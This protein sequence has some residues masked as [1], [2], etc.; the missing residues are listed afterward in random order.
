[1]CENGV[2]VDQLVFAGNER[3]GGGEVVIIFAI[4]DRIGAGLAELGFL[5]GA[6]VRGVG[7]IGDR[8]GEARGDLVAVESVC[9]PA[10]AGDHGGV[11]D[12]DA[13]ADPGDLIKACERE[14][15]RSPY[16]KDGGRP[17][18]TAPGRRSEEFDFLGDD[19][20]VVVSASV[21]LVAAV[22]A[23]DDAPP[24]FALLLLVEVG[25]VSGRERGWSY[26]YNMVVA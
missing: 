23:P 26:V 4:D 2:G 18:A 11:G 8:I 15:G 14:H 19:V 9:D 17:H 24:P 6:G 22:A 10:D 1:M 5:E 7:S 16:L 13:V 21:A 20:G 3:P 12:F 25:W